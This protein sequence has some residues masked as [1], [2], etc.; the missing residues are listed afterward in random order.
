MTF[1]LTEIQNGWVIKG[2]ED[3]NGISRSLFCKTIHVLSDVLM[4]WSSV[5]FVKAAER[6]R[7]LNIEEFYKEY[8]D[9]NL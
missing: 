8:N 1:L 3:Q 5:S 9:R 4:T 2:P 7:L 6:A